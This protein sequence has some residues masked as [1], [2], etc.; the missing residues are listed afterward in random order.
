VVESFASVP[1][2][3]NLSAPESCLHFLEALVEQNHK[4]VKLSKK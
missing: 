4:W 1:P 3:D 2:Q